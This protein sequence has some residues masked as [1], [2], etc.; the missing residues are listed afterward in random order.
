MADVAGGYD[1]VA[2]HLAAFNAHD[3]QRLLAGLAED[4]LWTTGR[5]RIRGR[6]AL[7]GI[8]D[9]WL[10]AMNPSLEPRAVIADGELAAAELTERLTV[11]GEPQQFPIAVFFRFA[12][13]LIKQATVYREGNAELA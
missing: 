10:W 13:G 5:D 7:A 9:D 4:A 3:T 2:E 1:W 8:F 11:E 12:D 6:E